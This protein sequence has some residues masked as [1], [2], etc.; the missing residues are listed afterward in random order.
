MIELYKI[1]T[2]KYEKDASIKLN[3]S[4]TKTLKL[5]VINLKYFRN[6]SVTTYRNIFF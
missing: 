4:V 5:E 2:E 3:V 1:V 6:T